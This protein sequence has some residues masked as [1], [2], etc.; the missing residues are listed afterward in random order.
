VSHPIYS[1]LFELYRSNSTEARCFVL[2]FLPVILWIF[3]SAKSRRDKQGYGKL[4]AILLAIYNAEVRDKN[5]QQNLKTF[6]LPSLSRPSLYHESSVDVM[7]QSALTESALS[8]HELAETPILGPTK[9]LNTVTAANRTSVLCIALRQYN[10]CIA[11]MD[12]TSHDSYW[13]M[14]IRVAA[15]GFSELCTPEIKTSPLADVINNEEL[16]RLTNHPRIPL[17]AEFIQELIHSLYF[18]MYNGCPV[19]AAR[20]IDSLHFRASHSLLAPAHVVSLF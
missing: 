20:A 4:E 3:L 1:T 17:N 8:R 9:Q 13:L 19:Q 11:F 5:D 10:S 12:K 7:S 2:Q 18:L 6:R 16:T 14:A 15:S